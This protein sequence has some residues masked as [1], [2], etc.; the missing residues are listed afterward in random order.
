MALC[1]IRLHY[2]QS[3]EKFKVDSLLSTKIKR[4]YG[5]MTLWYGI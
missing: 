2:R 4:D 3:L 1:S 5:K